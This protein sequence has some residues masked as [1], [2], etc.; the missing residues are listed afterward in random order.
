MSR[1]FKIGLLTFLVLISM[2][3]GYTFLKGRNLLTRAVELYSTYPDVTDLN[4]SSPVLVNGY[5]VGTVTKIK[6]NSQDVKKMDVFYLIDGNYKIPK[7]AV[8]VLKSL[9]FVSGKGI[10]LQ[11]EK[12]CNGSDCAVKG[13]KLEGT[14]VG[15]LGAMLGEIEVSEYSTEFTESLRA[16]I[17]NIGGPNEPGSL[18]ETV[19]Q[20]EIITKNV[21]NLTKHTDEV[22]L[23]SAN[24]LNATLSN[25]NILSNTLAKSSK[26]IENM[27]VQ[28][29]KFTANLSKSDIQGTVS[30]LNETLTDTKSTFTEFKTTLNSANKSLDALSL[31]L[32]NMNSGDGTMAK[33]M[34]D[35]KLYDN[36][37]LT[38]KNLSLL[39]QD[40]RL[41]PKRY[42]HFSVFGKRQKEYELP[43]SDPADVKK[44]D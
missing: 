42:A 19:R 7:N 3:W 44:I 33:L 37:D 31:T 40:L 18:N 10:F 38:T 32:G 36:L 15:L 43:D 17:A 2:I 34:N 5:K 13:D 6:L 26:N 25:V 16:V 12:E 35:K 28:M 14:N 1:E 24:N 30:N 11:F 20:L 21:A 22:I 29:D 23:A 8:A 39:L 41:N 4:V 9:G 27:L